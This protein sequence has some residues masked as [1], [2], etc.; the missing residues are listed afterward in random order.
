MN[1]LLAG[2]SVVL[3]LLFVLTPGTIAAGSMFRADPQHTGTFAT[4][5]TEPNNVLKWSFDEQNN[6]ITS[7]AVADGVVFFGSEDQHLYALHASNGTEKWEFATGGIVRSAPALSDGVVFF[8]SGDGNIYAL[9]AADGSVKWQV[10]TSP[11]YDG[12]GYSSPAISEGSVYVVSYDRNLYAIDA[13]TGAIRWTFP[14]VSAMGSET[15]SSPAVADGVVFFGDL[16]RVVYAVWAVNGTEKWRY[17]SPGAFMASIPPSAPVV[18]DGVLYMGGPGYRNLTA[19]WAENG[20]EKMRVSRG[21][22]NWELASPAIRDGVLYTGGSDLNLY[23]IDAATGDQIWSFYLGSLLR[24]SPSVSGDFVYAPSMGK[25]L[26]AIYRGNGTEKWRFSPPNSKG[27]W[28]APVISDGVVYIDGD[29]ADHLYAVGNQEQEPQFFSGRVLAGEIG[30]LTARGLRDVPVR[31]FGSD[32]PDEQGI[33]ITGTV[34]DSY[35][36][37]LIPVPEGTYQYINL[38][39]E[40]TIPG[41][42]PVGAQSSGGTVKN[43]SW[44]QYISPVDSTPLND[45]IFWDFVPTVHGNFTASR[46][47]GLAPLTVEFTDDSTG[48]PVTWNWVHEYNTTT[49]NGPITGL[50]PNTT[51]TYTE[52][53]VYSVQMRVFNAV[54]SD[55][56]TK[57]DYITVL[58][59]P[60]ALVIVNHTTAKLGL[61][62][63]SAIED[64][65]STLH[66]AYGH[67]SHGSQLIT[68]MNGLITF[69][70]A[71]YGGSLYQWNN[72][73]SGGALD[74]HDNF[75][76]GDLGNPDRTT[77]AERTREYLDNPA[78]ADVNVVIW[79]WCGQVDGSEADINTYL[80]LMNGLE[81]D[82]PDVRFV[83]MTGHLNGGGAAGNVNL[84]NEQI[85]AYCLAN[86]KILYDF[87]DIESYDPDGQTNY[88]VLYA[89][90]NCDYVSGGSHNWAIDWQTTHTQNVDWYA[91]SPAHTQALNGNL[92]AYA[93]WWLWARLA[94]WDGTTPVP[95]ITGISPA[96]AAAGGS[97]FTLTVNGTGFI[98]ASTV[99]WN[100]A[101]RTTTFVSPTQLTATIPAS[102]ITTA[103]TVEVSVLNPSPGGGSSESLTF[104]ITEG[105]PIPA[106]TGI[107]PD[108]G[109][110]TTTIA[111]TNLAGAN[112]NTTVKPTVKLNRTGYPDIVA[113]GVDTTSSS[114]ITCTLDL[115]GRAAGQWNVVVTNPDGQ[116][117]TGSSLFTITA[118]DPAPI[119]TGIT[120]NTGVNSTTIAITNLAG[121]YF[122]T[123]T[124]PSVKLNGTGFADIVATDVLTLSSS[125]ITCR[126]DLTGYPAGTRNVVVTNPDGQTGTL[127]NGFTIT[128]PAVQLRHYAVFRPSPGASWIFTDNLTGVRF[129]D[130]YGT[131]SDKPLVGDFNNDDVTDRAVF[132]N[133]QW[134][135]DLDLDAD[136]DSRTHF[137]MTGDIPLVGD[138]NNDGLTDRAVFRNGQWI[139]DLD[140]DGDV[141]R[142]TNYGIAGDI[143]LAGDIDGDGITDR[144]VFRNGQWIVDLGMDGIVD[145]RISFGLSTDIPLIGFFDDD[146]VTD[147]AVFRDGQWI[148]DYGFD[149]S[150]DRRAWFGTA[151]DI[152]LGWVES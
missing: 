15:G 8:G 76:A 127:G 7:P 70:G 64:A 139:V 44:I 108:T 42:N 48:S 109:V 149:G 72:G 126:F 32:S 31:L 3:L 53:G 117:G 119:V 136:V 83:Y 11:S 92:K 24:A 98:A 71:P 125:Q 74:L 86:N 89:N 112:F 68:G 26:Y 130:Q 151:G 40:D 131:G 129:R 20:T 120:P 106:V 145:S 100:G 128:T 97:Q 25:V 121:A 123:T 38:V 43:A 124:P 65:K 46:I 51:Y 62:P 118:P 79:S 78:N 69:P 104:T 47:S 95:G 111:I 17:T 91:C 4:G 102:D 137:G 18:S 6:R 55:W 61:V 148:I 90:D 36:Y 140:L 34:T 142:R 22:A 37:Y 2:S 14:F 81:A 35:G 9:N 54:S 66:I 143:P 105:N 113:S 77:W 28:G 49:G 80:T 27:L 146:T 21:Y 16:N 29:S 132:R 5:S 94:G 134:I 152:P 93:A 138:F 141:D 59:P 50:S 115:A 52:P 73:G 10:P 13:D 107:T 88:M 67:T 30:N 135:V 39:H 75:V 82:Y 133:G 19:L 114:R 12:I 110:N 99:L 103:G 45:N 85:R 23:A 96:S 57:V 58:A 144:A 87:A 147:R 116:S 1:R 60:T 84:R 122:N 33:L 150:V 41:S 56:V 63:R 101:N